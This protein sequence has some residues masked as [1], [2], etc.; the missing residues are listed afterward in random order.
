[1]NVSDATVLKT[2]SVAVVP[3]NFV[4]YE[5]GRGGTV[6]TLIASAPFTTTMVNK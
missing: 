4:H 6:V 1:V 3:P 5:G 2:G